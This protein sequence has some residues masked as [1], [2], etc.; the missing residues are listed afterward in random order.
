[1]SKRGHTMTIPDWIWN[2]AQ[3]AFG[4]ENPSS[5]LLDILSEEVADLKNQKAA[6][7]RSAAEPDPEPPTDDDNG[8]VF[9][10]RRPGICASRICGGKAFPAGE[11]IFVQN[12]RYKHLACHN[13]EIA[14]R[15][16][17]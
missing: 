3:S 11:E 17:K 5:R 15:E 2:W 12:H 13:Q 1:M 14:E 6:P 10:A 4:V 9:I 16:A 8:H 7:M